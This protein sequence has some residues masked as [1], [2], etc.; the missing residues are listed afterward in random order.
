[1]KI[2]LLKEVKNLGRKGEVK[3][4]ADGFARNFLLPQG[5]VMMA[6]EGNVKMYSREKKKKATLSGDQPLG[7]KRFEEMLKSGMK[8]KIKAKANEE[9][10]LFAG[11]GRKEIADFLE[12]APS[13]RLLRRGSGQVR[14][15]KGVKIDVKMIKLDKKIKTIGEHVVEVDVGEKKGELRVKVVKE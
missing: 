2:I 8:V 15:G 3:E 5:L 7:W 14:A 9:G 13:M 11:I 6:S 1:M 10:H 4:V 12:Q